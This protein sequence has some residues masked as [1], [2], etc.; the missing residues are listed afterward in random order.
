[1]ADDIP[2][3]RSFDAAPETLQ[4]V[5][6]LV[7]R[8]VAP[9][10][11]P[12]TFTG[13]CTYVVG[14]GAVA[15]IDPGP[16]DPAHIAAL[17][18]ALAGERVAQI[19][20]THTHRDHSPGARLLAAA[21]GAPIVGCGPHVAF[22]PLAEGEHNRL[23][24]S[25]DRDHAPARILQDGDS[26][27]GDGWTLQAV[28]TPGHTANHLAFAL[29]EENA[30]FSGDH[31]MAWS[32]TIVAPPDGAMGPYMASLN[33][34]QGR[35][36]RVYW[37]GHGGPVANPS[38]F[39]RALAHHRRQREASIL[40]RVAAGDGLIADIVPRLYDGLAPALHGAAALSVFAHLEDLAERGLVATDGPPGLQSR[41]RVA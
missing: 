39:V 7:R 5:S 26:I 3:D 19:V 31:V 34:L 6:P 27:A 18:A 4:Q 10:G 13:T 28:A 11:G 41:Y 36:D 38:R 29:P 15:V 23:E 12:F 16:D 2:F 8:M 33:R 1:M 22:R 30:L 9:N 25:G 35:D 14:H 17:Q 24:A 21:T 20:V 32:T 37:P 40:D